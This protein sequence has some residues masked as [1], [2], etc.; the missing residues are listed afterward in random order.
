MPIS[1]A[2]KK[3]KK[4][5]RLT[6][7]EILK[8]I[9][10]LKPKTQQTVRIN[11]GDKAG[12]VSGSSGSAP[13]PYRPDSGS[14][15]FT[16]AYAPVVPPPSAI[17]P[18]PSAPLPAQPIKAKE[19][20]TFIPKQPTF[21]APQRLTSTEPIFKPSKLSEKIAKQ[22]GKYSPAELVLKEEELEQEEYSY[23]KPSS[24]KAPAYQKPSDLGTKSRYEIF[25]NSPT[26][27]DPYYNA[28]ITT[29]GDTDQ[30]GNRTFNMSSDTW[31]LTPEGQTEPII[32]SV[33][34]T[35]VPTSASQTMEEFLKQQ[36]EIEQ[37][38]TPEITEEELP[39]P[40]S[41]KEELSPVKVPRKYTPRSP[42]VSE[43]SVSPTVMRQEVN[44]AIQRGELD[45]TQYGITESNVYQ[46]GKNVGLIRSTI[47]PEQLNAMYL[48]LK[49]SSY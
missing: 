15:I 38:Q 2:D 32:P 47:S 26:I 1:K 42:K 7:E 41:A 19:V 35:I 33:E 44:L 27:N 46:K 40:A 12:K 3:K 49:A 4:K 29:I 9:K 6:N 48:A 37:M 31:T 39:I 21:K 34:E 45:P 13:M 43:S 11:I 25:T 16:H 36:Q 17:Q 20:A 23:V 14:V 24:F 8:L 18:V 22:F 5:K 28:N 30:I 10:K